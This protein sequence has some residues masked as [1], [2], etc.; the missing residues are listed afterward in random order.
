MDRQAVIGGLQKTIEGLSNW[1]IRKYSVY[2]IEAIKFLRKDEKLRVDLIKFLE[3]EN[4]Y[5]AKVFMFIKK[6]DLVKTNKFFVNELGYSMDRLSGNM[7]RNIYE[8][9]TDILRG[10][11]K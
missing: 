11:I 6:E 3:T 10:I 2:L 5:P 7:G 9:I 8:S 1:S 4:P